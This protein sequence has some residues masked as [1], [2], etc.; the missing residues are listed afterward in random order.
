MF[1]NLFSKFKCPNCQMGSTIH[2]GAHMKMCKKCLDS[3]YDYE[4]FRLPNG[5]IFAI[6]YIKQKK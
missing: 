5:N 6:V 1:E 2:N 3:G 4:M